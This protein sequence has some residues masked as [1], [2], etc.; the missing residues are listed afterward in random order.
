M[1]VRI[2]LGVKRRPACFA[3]APDEFRLVRWES[4]RPDAV[5]TC[6]GPLVMMPESVNNA[7]GRVAD[8]GVGKWQ[9]KERGRSIDH[10]DWGGRR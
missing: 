2:G 9:G 10:P 5:T 3:R 4:E 7:D 1:I 6:N 8:M